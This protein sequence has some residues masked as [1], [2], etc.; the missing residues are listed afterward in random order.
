M[1]NNQEQFLK[2]DDELQFLSE[3]VPGSLSEGPLQFFF[4]SSKN[5]SWVLSLHEKQCKLEEQPIESNETFGCWA[6]DLMNNSW[7]LI[8]YSEI[9]SFQSWPPDDWADDPNS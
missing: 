6:W 7:T 1:E 5:E 4:K 8:Q 2:I 9:D 3:F